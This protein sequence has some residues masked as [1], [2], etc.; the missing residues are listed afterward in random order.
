LSRWI[1]DPFC[2]LSHFVGALLAIAALVVLL[3]LADGRPWHVLGFSIYGATLILLYV[4]ST[5]CHS[6]HCAP[7]T[8]DRLDRFDHVAIFLLIAGTYTPICLVPLRGPWGWTLLAL[9]WLL[10]AIGIVI[11]ARGPVRQWPRVILY[12]AMSWVVIIAVGPLWQALTPA[13]IAWLIAGGIVYTGGAVIY[14]MDRPHLWP[15]KFAAH[16]LWHVLVL[17]GSACH[18]AA[19]LSFV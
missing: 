1:K 4:A 17:I 9:E 16:D 12:L 14:A 18:F 2:G 3:M 13:A 8:A 5:L 10:A 7:R 15:G 11:I 19:M 6:V